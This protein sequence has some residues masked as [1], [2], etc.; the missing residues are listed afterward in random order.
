MKLEQLFQF[1]SV[2]QNGSI[3]KAAY[4]LYIS[5]SSLSRSIRL[6][7][8]E[9]GANLLVRTSQGISLTPFGNEVYETARMVCAGYNR[10]ER[11]K[12]EKPSTS[13]LKMRISA[14]SLTFAE[15][16]FTELYKKYEKDDPLFALAQEPV[17]Q[18][19]YDV[20]MGLS[21]LGISMISS[22]SV[23]TTARL[24]SSSQLDYTPIVRLP[25]EVFLGRNHPLAKRQSISINELMKY[26][27]AS[28]AGNFE[29]SELLNLL[30]QKRS[31]RN[32]VAISDKTALNRFLHETNAYSLIPSSAPC[33]IALPRFNTDLVVSV[34]LAEKDFF[35]EIGWFKQQGKMLTPICQ[36]YINLLTA[37]F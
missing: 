28:G 4:D 30:S 25:M 35:F 31:M 36:E 15:Y 20:K 5:Q 24:M 32:H 8:D 17:S 27:F 34:P 7:E 22:A 1:V 6:L 9:L 2:V 12:V 21:D 29:L 3:N 18:S 10:L 11:F 14:H 26:S 16:A 33:K 37:M 13:H 19:V 23:E